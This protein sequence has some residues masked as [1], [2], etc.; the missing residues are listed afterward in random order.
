MMSCTSV[1]YTSHSCLSPLSPLLLPLPL[2]CRYIVN[3]TLGSRVA[4]LN[5][6]W[7]QPYTDDSLMEGFLKAV[8]LAGV[9]LVT[10]SRRMMHTHT[11]QHTR[12][13]QTPTSSIHTLTHCSVL[14]VVRP[15]VL[16]PQLFHAH[17]CILCCAVLCRW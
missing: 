5:P 7:N 14:C 15:P 3:T 8:E 17:S 1:G 16:P 11:T 6:S 2:P 13:R 9:V 4:R 12:C 10:W